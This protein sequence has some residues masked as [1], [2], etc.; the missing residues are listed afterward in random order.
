MPSSSTR[1]NGVS[2]NSSPSSPPQQLSTTF[3]ASSP[4]P[5][6][7]SWKAFLRLGNHSAKKLPSI[8]DLKLDTGSLPSEATSATLTPLTP[9]HSLTPGSFASTDQRSSYNSSNTLSSDYNNN[10]G[11]QSALPASPS[12][13]SYFTPRPGENDTDDHHT[14]NG[15]SRSKSKADKQRILG[16]SNHK[17]PLTAHPSQSSFHPDTQSNS[18]SGPLSPKVIGANASRF[19][20]RVA[21]APNAKGL[22]S[23]GSRSTSATTKNGLLSPGEAMPPV[24][25]SDQ[26]ADSLESASSGAS[27]GRSPRQGRAHSAIGGKTKDRVTNAHATTDGPGKVAFRRTYSSHSIKVKEVSSVI[28]RVL[29]AETDSNECFL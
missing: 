27:R 13:P 26:G 21:S 24:P 1:A 25:Q 8:T 3:V 2:A 10:S 19:I 4:G 28:H 29:M 12:T 11:T 14:A 17:L 20:R 15:K 6:T 9:N 23:L 16:R 7:P 5:S 18:R 22:F